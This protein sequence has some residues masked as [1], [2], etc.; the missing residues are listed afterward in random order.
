M[1]WDQRRVS[2]CSAT[3]H[4]PFIEYVSSAKTILVQ[5]TYHLNLHI[6]DTA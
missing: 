5:Y 1:G 4:V 2:H 3:T 6:N